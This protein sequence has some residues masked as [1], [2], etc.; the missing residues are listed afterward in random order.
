MRRSPFFHLSHVRLMSERRKFNPSRVTYG[1]AAFESLSRLSEC[2]G[3]PFARVLS[4][5]ESRL[6]VVYRFPFRLGPA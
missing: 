2:V 6:C 5:Y 1:R 3:E 4:Q